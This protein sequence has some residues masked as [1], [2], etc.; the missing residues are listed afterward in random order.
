MCIRDSFREA[1]ADFT[2][3]IKLDPNYINAYAN[4]GEA[5]YE[6]THL[7]DAIADFTK[8]IQLTPNASNTYYNRGVAQSDLMNYHDALK[9]LEMA[10]KFKHPA[11]Q[12]AIDTI[13]ELLKK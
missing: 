7:R 3:T 9:D 8:V 11:A 2:E 10:L 12:S 1:I 13:Q 5:R 6:L 4:R